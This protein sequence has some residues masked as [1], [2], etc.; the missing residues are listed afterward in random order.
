[1]NA[2][3]IRK[4]FE[5]TAYTRMGGSKDELR[6]ARYLQEQCA[7]M[8]LNAS[9][10]AFPVPMAE[11]QEASFCVDGQNIPCRGLLHAG[12]AELEAPLYYLRNEDP[13]SLSQCKGKIVLLDR[14]PK[15]WLY[16]NLIDHGAVGL[17]FYEGNVGFEDREIGQRELRIHTHMGRRLPAV[18]IHAVDAVRL[19]AERA[20]TAKLLLKQQAREGESWNVV[21]DLPG[22]TDEYM[23]LTAHYDST[24]LSHGAYDNM[25]GCIGLLAIAEHFANVPHRYGLRFVWCGSEERGLLGSRAYAQSH[26]A[27]LEKAVL[28]INLDMIG[29]IMGY[30]LCVCTAEECLVDYLKAFSTEIGM[31]LKAY[32]GVYSSDST[33]FAD[34]GIPAVSFARIAPETVHTVHDQHDTADIM[35]IRQMEE[36]IG[37]ILEFVRRMATSECCPIPRSVPNKVREK[38]DDYMCRKRSKGD[39]LDPV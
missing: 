25:S 5:D 9:L 15:Y 33:P 12:S 21:L 24:S 31:G 27:E 18:N 14:Y 37:V 2:E 7:Q 29:C 17:V 16:Q 38:L 20:Q 1:M 36:D 6:A 28:N 39:P 23:V 30:F 10:E 8:G 32:Q 22:Q 34:L 11:I 19:V 4:V 26:Q 13:V 35:S 3:K